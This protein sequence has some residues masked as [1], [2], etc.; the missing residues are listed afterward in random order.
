[1]GETVGGF[2]NADGAFWIRGERMRKI[3]RQCGAGSSLVFESTKRSRFFCD[4]VYQ[5]GMRHLRP[6]R[7]PVT[8]R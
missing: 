7:V 8:R 6:R 2:M 1:M 5:T 3:A 4:Q